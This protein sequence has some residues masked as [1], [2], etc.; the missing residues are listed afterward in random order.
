MKTCENDP[1][2]MFLNVQKI[3][4]LGS[5][6][7]QVMRAT[8]DGSTRLNMFKIELELLSG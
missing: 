6:R 1:I 7:V 4:K 3:C 2:P 8:S 5:K